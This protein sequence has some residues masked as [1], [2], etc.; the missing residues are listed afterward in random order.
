MHVASTARPLRDCFDDDRRDFCLDPLQH[1][2]ISIH[3]CT[4]ELPALRGAGLRRAAAS[5]ASAED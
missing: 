2:S 5:V 1:A 3:L 4:N